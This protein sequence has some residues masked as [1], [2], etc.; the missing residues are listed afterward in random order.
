MATQKISEIPEKI[1]ADKY[2]KSEIGQFLNNSSGSLTQK[3]IEKLASSLKEANGKTALEKV[4]S[5]SIAIRA[6]GEGEKLASDS[7][8]ENINTLAKRVTENE[9]TQQNLRDVYGITRGDQLYEL[10]S[11]K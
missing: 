5:E 1:A 9:I 8:K 11:K 6:R 7:N 3:D 2:D 10:L 4:R